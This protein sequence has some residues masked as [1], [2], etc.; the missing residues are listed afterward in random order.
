MFEWIRRHNRLL[1]L[2]LLLLIFPA[3]AFFGISGYNT[4]FTPDNAVATVGESS[5]SQ[6]EFSQAHRGQI[7]NMKRMLGDQIDA[8]MFDTPQARLQV[9]ESLIDQRVLATRVQENRVSVSDDAVRAAITQIPGVLKAD[10]SF[11]IEQYRRLLQAQG[12]NE[13]QF[14]NRVRADLAIRLIPTAIEST[15]FVPS[16]VATQLARLTGQERVLRTRSFKPEDYI[17]KVEVDAATVRKHYDEHTEQFKSPESATINYLVLSQQELAAQVEV[18]DEEKKAYYDQNQRRYGQSEQRAASHILVPVP[19][20]ASD[21]VR[22]T[23]RLK[24]E[25]LLARVRGGESF[26]D[27][28]RAESGDPGSA[29]SGGD[30]GFF[31]RQTMA[32]GFADAAFKLAKDAISDV[33]QTEFGYHIIRLTDIRPAT[34]KPYE[35]VAAQVDSELREE[36]A[37]AAFAEKADV[38]SNTVYEQPDSLEP[39][40][41]KVGLTIG[42]INDFR[43]L[44]TPDLPPGSPLADPKV[45]RAVFDPEK[46][47]RK[48]NSEAIDL[49]NGNLV[50]VR[51]LEHRPAAVEP[52]EKV[53]AQVQA[54]VRADKA[55]ELAREAGEQALSGLLAGSP[56]GSNADFG[57]P[58]TITRDARSL[59]PQAIAQAFAQPGDKLPG[60]FGV[61]LG[62]GGYLIGELVEVREVAD[63]KLA[64]AT[65]SAASSAASAAGQLSFDA[66]LRT[67]KDSLAIERHT[68]R[69]SENRAA[70]R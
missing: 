3:F 47:A 23:A 9:L 60:Y 29:E 22:E 8:S 57:E 10:G 21:A 27:V 58:V 11:D 38:F 16:T 30:L 40:A 36:K 45:A 33:V 67:V 50:S 17:N 5:V 34:I 26:A 66:W 41:A 25:A 49:G 59:A 31:D 63:D 48:M 4:F 19:E 20:G 32:E 24:A 12:M 39:A 56:T 62:R 42:K 2:L 54:I 18:T 37:R 64:A 51:V 61:S 14:E 28:A 65:E 70:D 55:A 43:R 69:I 44:G 52:F 1:Q 68:D 6:Q 15:A 13:L 7:D 46:L 53:E 35:Q